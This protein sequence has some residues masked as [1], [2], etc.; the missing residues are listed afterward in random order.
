MDAIAGPR[1][2]SAVLT[3]EDSA[4][5]SRP[6]G[7]IGGALS[8]LARVYGAS[9]DAI[10]WM[11]HLRPASRL[12]PGRRLVLRSALHPHWMPQGRY[13]RP[14][15]LGG[16]RK[17]VSSLAVYFSF[18]R[19]RT[20]PFKGKL[21]GPLRALA[22]EE[23]WA[24]TAAVATRAMVEP[25]RHLV[26]ALSKRKGRRRFFASLHERLERREF[27]SLLLDIG[28]VPPGRG[29]GLTAG[30][31]ALKK[32]FPGLP[33][34]A[35][36][37]PPEQGWKSLIS[38]LDYRRVGESVDRFLLRAPPVGV[39]PEQ[40]KWHAQPGRC[41]KVGG[42]DDPASP[43]VESPAWSPD[44]RLPQDRDAQRSG[45]PGRRRRRSEPQAPARA[46]ENGFLC[47]SVDEGEYVGTYIL[48]GREVFSRLITLAYRYRLAGVFLHP[49]G[50]EDRR[51]WDVLSRRL[52]AEQL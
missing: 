12:S 2:F 48:V 24:L 9:V 28:A 20:A 16:E 51:L 42:P 37:A 52:W 13:D 36:L 7:P 6:R 43:T 4:K 11:N 38:D 33:V 14:A 41:R 25:G 40:T 1:K 5:E 49:V 44:G 35:A 45:V 22:Q 21:T 18:R 34:T 27:G 46:E 10:R 50:L 30:L 31:V 26:G 29:A 47:F 32:A 23:G 8:D 17:N 15:D 19:G 3:R 39:S